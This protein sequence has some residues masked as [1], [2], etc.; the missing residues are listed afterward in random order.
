MHRVLRLLCLAPLLVSGTLRAEEAPTPEPVSV[1]DFFAGGR[2]VSFRGRRI[3]LDYD[4]SDPACL[5]DFV[6]ANPFLQAPS[7]GFEVSR[8]KLE[9][10]GVGALVHKGVFEADITVEAVVE[11]ETPWDIGV[12]LVQPGLTDRFLLFALS[13]RYFSRK[14]RQ[15]PNQHMITVVGAEVTDG[16]EGSNFRYLTRTREPAL[17][18]GGPLE[19][20]V[21]KSGDRNRFRFAGAT[22]LAADRHGRFPAVRPAL[23]VLQSSMTVRSLSISGMLRESFLR[24]KRIRF[25]PDERD[26]V[27][28]PRIEEPEAEPDPP[29]RRGGRGG[30]PWGRRTGG[31]EA[32]G[33]VAKLRDTGLPEAEREQAAGGLDRKNVK[34][35]EF[36]ALLDTLYS[37]DLVTRSLAIAVLKRVTGKTLG[38][39]PKAPEEHR[40]KTIRSWFKFFMQHRDRFR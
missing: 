1:E 3:T 32:M 19:I 20:A 28:P 18:K 36:K 39:N 27:G 10:R 9:A 25:D 34:V 30:R 8:G 21:A 14:D 17:E 7:G 5:A 37:D 35:D 15:E 24:E 2:V 16:D 12:L 38:Y 29:P 23:Y 40:R 4:W 6:E 31:S 13:D 11:S 22:L 33:L 26:P